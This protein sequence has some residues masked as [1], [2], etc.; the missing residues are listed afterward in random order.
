MKDANSYHVIYYHRNT[1]NAL[2][3]QDFK[4]N[5]NAVLECTLQLETTFGA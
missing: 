4:M 1:S 5:R 3:R 2:H